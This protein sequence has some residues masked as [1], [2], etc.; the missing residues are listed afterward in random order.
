MAL[1]A[2]VRQTVPIKYSEAENAT[3]N[4]T[5]KTT[6]PDIKMKN[7]PVPMIARA[8]EIILIK[9]DTSLNFLKLWLY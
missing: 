9:E 4:G 5:I 7:A 8:D 2:L 1:N 6:A 3:T